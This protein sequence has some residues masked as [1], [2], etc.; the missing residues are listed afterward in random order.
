[1][2]S[3]FQVIDDEIC[4][5]TC[6]PSVLEV[7]RIKEVV[8]V[9][10]DVEDGMEVGEYKADVVVGQENRCGKRVFCRCHRCVYHQYCLDK[11]LKKN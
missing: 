11:W 9:V 1:M 3:I 10:I 2:N 7:V 8:L 4:L 5:S 6:E